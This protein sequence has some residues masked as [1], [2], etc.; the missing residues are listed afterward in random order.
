MSLPRALTQLCLAALGAG[1]REAP[2][3]VNGTVIVV[4][5]DGVRVEESFG[6]EPSSATGGH[7]SA[8]LPNVWSELFPQA[9]RATQAWNLTST[10]T[11]P[12]HVALMTGRRQAVA[13][14][15]L[16]VNPGQY[17]PE[18][19]TVVEALRRTT[20][21]TRQ[22]AAIIANTELVKPAGHSLW[23][24]SGYLHGAEFIFVTRG[25]SETNPSNDDI[26][27][28]A[29]LREQLETFP[30]HFALLNLHQVDRSGHYGDED[31]YLDD[32][33]YLDQDLADLWGWIQARPQYAG[34]TWLLLVADHGRHSNAAT[35][36]PWRHHGC[37]CNGCRR[38]PFLLLGPGV[39]DGTDY[40]QPVLL[41]DIGP[42]M[43]ALLGIRMPWADGIVQ[44]GLFDEPTGIP[45]RSG[46]ADLAMVE[47]LSA[48]LLYL[49]D[50]AQRSELRVDG[51]LLSDPAAFAVEAPALAVEGERAWLCFRELTLALD[52]EDTRW[53]PRCFASQDA[54]LSWQDIGA[55][56]EEVGPFWSAD[57]LTDGEDLLA[58]YGYNP[59]GIAALGIDGSDGEVA[60]DV[61][62]YDGEQWQVSSAGGNHTFPVGASAASDGEQLYLAIGAAG[63]GTDARY[64]RDIYVWRV[65]L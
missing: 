16:D 55:P 58:V 29:A 44:D 1:C 26:E 40:D 34:D 47:G 41:E 59:H 13:N 48:E 53:I 42:T 18:L 22:Q 36:P 19:P 11:T 15:P 10:T 37:Q 46:L 5:M 21:V 20:G 17:R 56:R 35:E 6:E 30:T 7:P 45:S 8:F 28:L 60:V 54:G 27:V 3:E 4:V 50:P 23:P 51:E 14:Y 63:T 31:A 52:E 2:V 38:V 61:A 62:R 49:D 9:V 32:V 24:G 65:S 33:R 39:K 25:A 12:A 43:G 57:L 64:T